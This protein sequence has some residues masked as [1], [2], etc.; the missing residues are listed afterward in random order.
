MSDVR[1]TP[2]AAT[3]LEHNFFFIILLFMDNAWKSMENDKKKYP[4][5]YQMI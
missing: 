5:L 4:K 3:H 2:K 1:F